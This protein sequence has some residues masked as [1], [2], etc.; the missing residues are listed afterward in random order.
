MV[1]HAV[2]GLLNLA[3]CVARAVLKVGY[4]VSNFIIGSEG[5]TGSFSGESIVISD[6]VLFPHGAIDLLDLGEAG[7]VSLQ[8]AGLVRG[9]GG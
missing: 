1:V 8:D 7:T 4:S 6:H 9:G 5:G 2:Q 3:H